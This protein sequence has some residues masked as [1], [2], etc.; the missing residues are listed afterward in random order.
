MRQR[1]R[2]EDGRDELYQ[3]QH[4]L[5]G[6]RLL[7][8]EAHRVSA[9]PA[10][11]LDDPDLAGNPVALAHA[12]ALGRGGSPSAS[13]GHPVGLA[14]VFLAVIPTLILLVS[15]PLG[16]FVLFMLCFGFAYL[17]GFGSIL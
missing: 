8:G 14:L 17:F 16:W 11:I 9:R 13:A 7:P 4:V 5:S 6:I 3:T 1:V 12:R 15:N 2:A 10:S